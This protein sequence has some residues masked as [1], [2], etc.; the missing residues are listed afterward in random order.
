MSTGKDLAEISEELSSFIFRTVRI[1]MQKASP[2][3]PVVYQSTWR[4]SS[5]EFTLHY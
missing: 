2:A 1:C 5:Q 3:M 4:P